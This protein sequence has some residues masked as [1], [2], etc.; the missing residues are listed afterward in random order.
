MGAQTKPVL[1]AMSESTPPPPSSEGAIGERTTVPTPSSPKLRAVSAGTGD[2]PVSARFAI[3]NELTGEVD[4]AAAASNAPSMV[5]QKEE[6]ARARGF[7]R[8][9][10]LLSAV[11]IA[12]QAI[13]PVPGWMLAVMMPTLAVMAATSIWMYRLTADASRYTRR[14]ARLFGVV[15]AVVAIL[16]TYCLGVFSPAP[17]FITLGIT[18]FGLGEDVLSAV[19]LPIVVGAGYVL[20]ASLI[21]LGVLPDAGMTSAF[22]TPAIARVPIVLTV[23]FVYVLALWQARLSRRATVEAITR[24]SAAVREML[25]RDK[26]LQ[27]ANRDLDRLLGMGSGDIGPY[28]GSTCGRYVLGKLV[29]RG[30]MGEVYGATDG[31]SGERAAVKLLLPGMTKD[32]NLVLRFLREGEAASKLR[33]PNVVSI[34]EVGKNAEG[35]PYIAMELLRGHDLGWHLRHRR[36]LS[37]DEVVSIADQ[38]AAGLEVARRAGIVHRDL[39]PQN[40]FLAQQQRSAPLWKL[41]DFGV[42][43][44]AGSS[45]TLTKD[46]IVGTP[47]Y[48][49]PEA[50]SGGDA[51]HRSDVFSFGAV[52]YRALT[53]QPP[54]T[55]PD[56]PQILYQVVYRN[57]T[58]P[59]E[60]TPELP[61][62]VDLVLAIALAKDKDDRFA[63]ALELA[64]A[65]RAAAKSELDAA[66]R[67]HARTVLAALP[68]GS[69]IRDSAVV[70]DL[71]IEEGSLG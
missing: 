11:G 62:D 15:A 8:A 50:A 26:Q 64:T 39:K 34:Y 67:L 1:E 2:T 57:P 6:A 44:L 10:I 38:V 69:S 17:I 60:L 68:W 20:V 29:G 33:A 22:A 25:Q 63:S 51:T 7:A 28:T 49:S 31:K 47:G 18:F 5:L 32:Q 23:P 48:M 40:V 45:G 71:M 53:G 52:I 19:G 56:T 13:L 55:A 14:R 35:S 42:S 46:Q 54:F 4:P 24:A 66:H 30:A 43:R 61:P 58:R 27:E 37:L 3:G 9:L 41:L 16:V 21:L 59:G 12:A 65:L 70:P 36:R